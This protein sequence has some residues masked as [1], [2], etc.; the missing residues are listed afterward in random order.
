VV[1]T[2]APFMEVLDTSIANVA[3]PHISGNLGAGVDESTWILTSYL[4]SNAIVLITS[5]WLSSLLGRKRYYMLSVALFTGSSFL[6]GLAPSLQA[7][8]VF[9]LFQGIGGGG[10]QPTTQAILVDVFPPRQR[11]MGMAVYGMTVVVAPI[12]G[13]TLGGWITDNFSWRWI[14]F[15]NVPVGFLSLLLSSRILSDPPHLPRRTGPDRFRVDWVGLGLL[16]LGLGILQT[17]LDIGER[18]DWFGT[19]AI[20]VA[21][22]V[23]VASLTLFVVWELGH[24]DPIVDLGLLRDRNL[25]LSSVVMLIFGVVLYGS[26]VL[27]PLLMQTLLGYTATW[28][29]LAVSPGGVVV[30]V[31]MPLIGWLLSRVD[32]RW[33][34]LLGIAV[35]SWSLLLMGRFTVDVDFR[36]IVQARLVQGF[37]LAFLFVPIN[38][39]AYL[40][41]S[42]EDRNSASSL[43]SLARNIGGSF[44]ISM[45]TTLLER[46]TQVHQ[47]VLV[48]HVT[49]YDPSW[50]SLVGNLTE[51]LERR[52]VLTS[53][54][55]ELAQGILAQTVESQARMLAYLD[56]FRWLAVSFLVLVP[57]VFLMKRSKGSGGGLA[58]IH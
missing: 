23:S 5:A 33:L 9:R 4:I 22:A 6:C 52:T 3:L 55:Q 1:A 50:G 40:N 21:S 27:L 32:L 12:I 39:A 38:T 8:V 58:G 11:G 42:K 7:L 14:F 45:V 57:F 26:I 49:P 13:P 25:A 19:P 51:T 10:L 53:P 29:G 35:V 18:H 48:T 24:P 16:S 15:I 46:R 2:L 31:L 28:S 56:L 37:G 54:A 47:S 41:V 43:I 17:V 20:L 34:I 30:M 36:T 44:G